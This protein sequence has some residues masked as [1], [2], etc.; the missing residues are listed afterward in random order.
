MRRRS[1]TEPELLALYDRALPEVY[2]YFSPRCGSGS[3]HCRGPHVADVPRSRWFPRTWHGAGDERRVAHR[4]RSPQTRRP[5]AGCGT[6]K[7]ATCRAVTD[8][9]GPASLTWD[10][11]LEPS[12]A[13]TVLHSLGAHHRLALTLRYVDE[14]SGA[15]HR[16]PS[17]TDGARNGGVARPRSHRV[18]F[19]ATTKPALAVQE[20]S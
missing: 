10:V 7:N 19:D 16:R 11:D 1:I 3:V 4:H 18:S 6:A 8:A 15:P 20:G 2:G 17:G 14:L 12:L 13:E 9:D 5:L